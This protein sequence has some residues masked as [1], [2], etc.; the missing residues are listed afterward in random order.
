MKCEEIFAALEMLEKEGL[1]TGY[2]DWKKQGFR[3][4]APGA[5]LLEAD[6]AADYILTRFFPQLHAL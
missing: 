3:L 5:P 4:A 6:R 2:R 1:V